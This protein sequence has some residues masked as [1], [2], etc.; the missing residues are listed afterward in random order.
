M[1]NLEIY[2]WGYQ[3]RSVEALLEIVARE[4]IDLVVDVRGNPH[5]RHPEW[6]KEALEQ[7]LG[8]RYSWVGWLGD[9]NYRDGGEPRLRDGRR[10]MQEL[11][12]L[13][14]GGVGR[15]L[16]LCYERNWRVCHRQAVAEMARGRFP[17][18][19]VRHLE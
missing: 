4:G 2:T 14:S 19:Q 6:S 1:A 15:V 10:G 13:V 3:G 5:S 9:E 8:A 11:G 16:L 17:G 7:L 12:R 18:A